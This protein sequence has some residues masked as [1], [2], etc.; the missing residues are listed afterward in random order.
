MNKSLL[1]VYSLVLSIA[2]ISSG[3]SSS[4][5]AYKDM[6]ST[7]SVQATD[8]RTV[9][10]INN[11]KQWAISKI[12]GDEAWSALKQKK[13]IK[14][15]VVDTGVDYNHPDLKNRVLKD[16][17]YNFLDNNKDTMDDN[18][19]GTHVAG[20]IA[21]D[22]A[23]SIGI[24]GVVGNADVKIIPIK[25]L[26]KNGQGSSDIIAKGI[27]YAA[28]KEADIIN[29]SVGFDVKDEFIRQAIRYAR[30]KGSFVVVSAGNNN[31]NCDNSS[32][33]GDEGAYTV[34]SINEYN[35][36]SSFSN[37]GNSIKIAAPG[38]NILSTIPKGDY[39]YKNGTSMAAPYIAGVA[40]MVK[41]QNPGLTPEDIEYILDKTAD[42]IMEKGKDEETGYG[43]VNAKAAVEMASKLNN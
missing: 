6:P 10:D 2:L 29:F 7:K 25:V 33:A 14:V 20:I 34:S 17:G 28:D 12:K 32:P 22:G 43:L 24:T 35:E 31:I 5:K 8:M 39:D 16:E 19:H 36:K 37:Y 38:E 27:K 11:S 9:N 1:A 41:A 3:C 15:A 26:D 21:A 23:N 4:I 30:T 40:A 42:D 18:W 13:Q